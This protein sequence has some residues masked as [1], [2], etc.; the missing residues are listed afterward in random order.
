MYSY[1]CTP[2]ATTGYS[3]YYMFFGR[4]PILPIDMLLKRKEGKVVR[5]SKVWKRANEKE[6]ERKRE[7]VK[8]GRSILKEGQHV[9]IS[10]HPISRN[11]IQ[12]RYKPDAYKITHLLSPQTYQIM[13]RV[14]TRVVNRSNVRQGDN[15][16]EHSI[17]SIPRRSSRINKGV[18]PNRY[19][20][21]Q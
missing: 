2:H 1:N 6:S 10:H 19:G 18:P 21:T 4:E 7:R 5:L 14:V 15:L 20:F 12:A 17:H 11:K 8:A 13:R 3:P 9:H 16:I